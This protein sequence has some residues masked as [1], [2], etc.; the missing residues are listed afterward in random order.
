MLKVVIADDEEK[1]CQL[2]KKLVDWES[3]DMT[4][5]AAVYNGVEAMEAIEKYKPDVVISDI[6]MP[7]YDGLDVIRT[8]RQKGMKTEFIIIS[9]YRHFEYAQNA[10][11]YGVSAYLL[12]PIKKE[13]LI[14]ALSMI[15]DRLAYNKARLT[16]EE[17]AKRAIRNDV[18]RERRGFVETI[19]SKGTYS[20]WRRISCEE[21]NARHHF[22]FQEGYYKC[23]IVK[24]DHMPE[25][26]LTFFAEETRK[27]LK[28]G[29]GPLCYEWEFLANR[30]E[31][32][33]I[34]N[35][36][37]ENQRKVSAKI[38]A[39][40]SEM[41]I[42]VS[43]FGQTDVTIGTGEVCETF[44]ELPYSAKIARLNVEQR[45][46]AGRNRVIEGRI[47][48]SGFLDSGD[49]A[50]FNDCLTE[51]AES[52][53]PETMN[54][55]LFRIR[56]LLVKFRNISGHEVLQMM[57]EACNV[58]IFAMKKLNL[59]VEGEEEFVSRYNEG[60]EWCA[61][62]GEL[63]ELLKQHILSSYQET[64]EKKKA[65]S[66]RP[67]R[68]AKKY[69]QEH[70]E[71]QITLEEVSAVTGFTPTYFSTVFK[72]STGKTFLEYLL[73][74]RMEA[75]KQMLR[76][77]NE[78]VETICHSVGYKDIKYFT[79]CFTKYTGLKPSEYRKIYA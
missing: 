40:M 49:F 60:A 70:F 76:E 38:Y 9:G 26:Q 8:V 21:I 7:G 52:L 3:M 45:L 55:A 10:I 13:E 35:F 6:R 12:K 59:P 67:V 78:K 58:Y 54:A 20:E 28:D 36:S 65:E 22:H 15:R 23:L 57:K 16:M 33:V 64:V 43:E 51:A 44:M 31:V 61:S 62:T 69:I 17:R 37:P 66:E 79:K 29:I 5:I 32:D 34:L 1:I 71:S 11:N 63:F 47:Q 19:F 48:E 18:E 56:E 2:I 30:N 68:L 72:K 74:V 14:H 46:I 41:S 53:K 50:E 24:F 42:F 25:N 77:G 27:K 4:V 73:S 39:I 75:A